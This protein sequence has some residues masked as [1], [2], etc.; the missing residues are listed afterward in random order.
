MAVRRRR[1]RSVAPPEQGW[2]LGA[3]G[4]PKVAWLVLALLLA[5]LA[6]FLLATGYVGYGAMIG[7]LAAAAAVNLI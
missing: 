3:G 7:V 4:M 2:A 5:G 6:V 1:R